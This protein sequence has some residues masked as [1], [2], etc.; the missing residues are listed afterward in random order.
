MQL[1]LKLIRFGTD[2]IDIHVMKFSITLILQIEVFYYL[3]QLT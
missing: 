3:S 1:K 2:M